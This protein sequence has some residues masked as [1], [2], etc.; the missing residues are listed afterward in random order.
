MARLILVRHATSEW[1]ALGIWTGWRDIGLAPEAEAEIM[2]LA[3]QLRDV[4]IH[5]AYSST[6]KRAVETLCILKGKLGI[7][8]PTF[9]DTAL[10]ERDYGV[11]TGKNK[12]EVKAEVGEEE[13]QQIRRSW[14]HPIPEGETLEDVFNRIAPFYEKTLLPEL[15]AGKDLLVVAHGNS[16]RALIKHLENLTSAEVLTREVGICE[17][18]MYVIDP[19]GVVVSK[20]VRAENPHVGKV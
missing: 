4:H 9:E 1:N 10:N 13:F 17:A 7:T 14:D 18:H 20:E 15:R 6:L 2:R 12:W 19:H 8:V 11:Y 5:V 16:L 3:D